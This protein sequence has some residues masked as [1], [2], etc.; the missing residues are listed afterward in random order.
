MLNDS[1]FQHLKLLDEVV[2]IQRAIKV[3][4]QMICSRFKPHF[5]QLIRF[6]V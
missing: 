2:V 4:G 1:L 6:H 3:T 5:Y